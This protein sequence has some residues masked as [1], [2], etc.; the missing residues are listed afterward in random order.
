MSSRATLLGSR[1]LAR[2]SSTTVNS[3]PP[4]RATVCCGA[5][6]ALQ[7]RGGGLEQAV[8]GGVAE[9]VVDVLEAVEVEEQHRDARVLPARAH[10]RARQALRQQRAVGQAGEGVV[11]GEV[12]QFL[13]GA[14]LVGD[15]VDH[16]DEVRCAGRCAS[17][18]SLISIQPRNSSPSLRRCH[19]SPAQWPCALEAVAQRR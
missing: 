9:R 13:L 16:A 4:R 11:V 17:R 19:I 8:A 18:T 15:V 1:R 3:S 7:A 14:L 10:D 2:S 6:G 12:A 5:D